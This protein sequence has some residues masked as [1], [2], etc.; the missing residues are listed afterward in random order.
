M[1]HLIRK[2]GGNFEVMM[3]FAS[4]IKYIGW[5]KHY[6]QHALLRR[7]FYYFM[8]TPYNVTISHPGVL[9]STSMTDQDPA[10]HQTPLLPRVM[11]S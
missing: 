4:W 11:L 1:T 8:T 3:F 7:L 6:A 9:G 5:R 2:K 10:L